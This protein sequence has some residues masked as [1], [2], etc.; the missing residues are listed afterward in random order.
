MGPFEM[1]VAIVVVAMTAKVI[2]EWLRH[3]A[4]QQ[5]AEPSPAVLDE[6]E[7]LRRRVEALETIVTDGRE[8]LRRRFQDLEREAADRRR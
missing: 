6:L 4:E 7:Q 1:V 5:G 2:Q 3:R 8:D